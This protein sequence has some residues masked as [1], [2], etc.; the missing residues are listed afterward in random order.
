[1]REPDVRACRCRVLHRNPIEPVRANAFSSSAAGAGGDPWRSTDLYAMLRCHDQLAIT[2]TNQVFVSRARRPEGHRHPR[3]ETAVCALVNKQE[4]LQKN[5]SVQPMGLV[6]CSSSLLITIF[7]FI[8][9]VAAFACMATGSFICA[10]QYVPKAPWVWITVL[11][12][13]ASPA[14]GT[15]SSWHLAS[16]GCC[17]EA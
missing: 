5:C 6:R 17:S 4:A 2:K 15:A 12:E 8:D 7:N 11:S 14:F 16:L 10:K 9:V 13:R 1:M 3:Q